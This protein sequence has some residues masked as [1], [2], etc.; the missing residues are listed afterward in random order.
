ML[1]KSGGRLIVALTKREKRRSKMETFEFTVIATGL[2]PAAEDFEARFFDAGCDDAMVSFQKGHILVD[3]AREAETL[4]VAI[5][6][7]V[8]NVEKA[9]ATIE[10]VEPDPMVSLSDIAR[11]ADLSRAALTNYAKGDRGDGFPAPKL[12]VTSD[13][14]LWDWA[15]ASKWLFRHRRLTRD[16]AINAMVVSEANEVIDCG[17][18]DFGSDLHERVETRMAEFEAA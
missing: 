16:V 4:E 7:A 3:F 5:T 18:E 13:S 11:R 8:Q 14:P 9:G 1:A 6:S 17:Y 12:R 15:D 2:D 10:R